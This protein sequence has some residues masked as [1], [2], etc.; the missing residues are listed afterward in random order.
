[1][2]RADEQVERMLSGVITDLT[3]QH[4]QALERVCLASLRD[5]A[6]RGV[7]AV[8]EQRFDEDDRAYRA[9]VTISLSYDVPAGEIHEYPYGRRG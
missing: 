9:S 4:R 7:L 2:S 3:A 1:M 8:W 6:E 5:P